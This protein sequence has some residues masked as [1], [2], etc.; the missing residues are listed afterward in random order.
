MNWLVV[1]CLINSPFFFA[2]IA[3]PLNNAAADA[4]NNQVLPTYQVVTQ[5]H[6]MPILSDFQQHAYQIG[7]HI[8]EHLYD[9]ADID[10]FEGSLDDLFQ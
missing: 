9:T 4:F 6:C 1:H 2:H 8:L 7:D 3:S 10:L 5:N